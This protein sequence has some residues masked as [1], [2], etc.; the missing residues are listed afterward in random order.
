M[1]R[2]QETPSSIGAIVTLLVIAGIFA[3]HIDC[4]GDK[5]IKQQTKSLTSRDVNNDGL[6]DIVIER[7]GGDKIVYYGTRDGEYLTAEQM[8]QREIERIETGY[9]EQLRQTNEFYGRAYDG[10]DGGGRER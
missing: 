3:I 1:E 8:K 2:N 4:R 10:N 7:Q 6:T 5:R 9:R